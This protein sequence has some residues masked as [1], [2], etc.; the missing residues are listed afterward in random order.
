MQPLGVALTAVGAAGVAGLGK[1]VSMAADFQSQVALMNIAAG[2]TAG[3]DM[4]HDAA[5]MVGGDTQLVG[6]TAS[7]AA[8]SITELLKAGMSVADV[9]G[10]V[11]SYMAGNAELGG[12][13]RAS[14]DLAAASELDMA[15]GAEV[16]SVAMKT[17]GIDTSEAT[18]ITDNFVR[19]ADASVA[20]VGD[21][22]DAQR[23]IGPTAAAFGWSI[24]DTNTALGILSQR[25][26]VGAEAGTAL[27][28]MM[29]NLMSPTAKVGDAL[30]DLNVELYD[31]QGNLKEIPT[32]VGELGFA[33]EGVTEKQRNQYIQTLAGTYGMKAMN[34]LLAEG[35]PGWQAMETSIAGAATAADIA[36]VKTNTLQGRMEA[37][38]GAVEAAGISLGETYLDEL[39]GATDWATGAVDAFNNLSPEIKEVV[40]DLLLVGTAGSLA[41]GGLILFAPK[42]FDTVRALKALAVFTGLP[43]LLS[44][45]GVGFGLMWSG[46][47]SGEI[48][49]LGFGAAVGGIVAPLAAL[50]G[51]ILL[52]NKLLEGHEDTIIDASSSYEQ[53][54][55][56]MLRAGEAA[57]I[58]SEAEWNAA[59]RPP[60]E[61][62]KVNVGEIEGM[63]AAQFRLA[64][65]ALAVGGATGDMTGEIGGIP[66]V[67]IPATEALEPLVTVMGNYASTLASIDTGPSAMWQ[68]L[69]DTADAAGWTA[70]MIEEAGVATG[71]FAEADIEAYEAQVRF[72]GLMQAG[73]VD[74]AAYTGVTQALGSAQGEAADSALKQAGYVM[75][76]AEATGEMIGLYQQVPGTVTTT[77]K[78]PGL[79]ASLTGVRNYLDT[80]NAIPRTKRV[81]IIQ[82][83][84]TSRGG[85]GI[86]GG[87]A[88]GTDYVPQ[89]APYLLHQGEAVL[90][91]DEAAAYRRGGMGGGTWNGD[92]NISGAGDPQATAAAVMRELQDRGMFSGSALR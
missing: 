14:I 38:G 26:I 54:G 10:D 40:S 23:N 82:E 65:S 80:I 15:A 72:G 25:G 32:I 83:Y 16:V 29:T 78:T 31:A 7:G 12:V 8:E 51:V 28:S 47:A 37:L 27:K 24:Y 69:V 56:M 43:T 44:N 73:L 2:D 6:V 89:T 49:A 88:Q 74:V 71:M 58:M 55:L 63:S 85:S 64:D 79:A 34:T 68:M 35:V 61:L 9:F 70:E 57:K 90:P 92:I 42:I 30:A 91:T 48:A 87:L 46:V 4:L 60:S 81:S 33:L 45:I 77:I 84:I 21:L 11:N 66:G 59:K 1:A 3:L 76:V 39:T 75:D 18:E 20:S 22:A 86:A 19:T 36:E 17:Y 53:Y 62:A 5:L 41:A 50:A 52:G 13:L 67:A